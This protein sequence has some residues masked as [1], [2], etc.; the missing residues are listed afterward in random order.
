MI[1]NAIQTILLLCN[2]Y[3]P[4][5]RLL[6]VIQLII[7]PAFVLLTIIIIHLIIELYNKIFGYDITHTNHIDSTTRLAIDSLFYTAFI[8][9]WTHVFKRLTKY[10]NTI[11]NYICYISKLKFQNIPFIIFI[12]SFT[13]FVIMTLYFNLRL[14]IVTSSLLLI[15]NV[16]YLRF[17]PIKIKEE[18]KYS[19]GPSI[20]QKFIDIWA[21]NKEFN[22]NN[23]KI[24]KNTSNGNILEICKLNSNKIIIKDPDIIIN[25]SIMTR[26]INDFYILDEEN[27]SNYIE[28][29][30][31]SNSI[32]K[33]DQT[34]SLES[35]YILYVVNNN[36]IFVKNI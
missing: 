24:T 33:C 30:N 15:F 16:I 25:K 36:Y 19:I 4:T 7:Y 23:L 21:P 3:T 32:L 5:N 35:E 26:K 14:Y 28:I 34:E 6:Q 22:I 1:Y 2:D 20:K 18:T 31:I 27:E 8:N 12:E 9:I 29:Q 13:L 17:S 11:L 10:T